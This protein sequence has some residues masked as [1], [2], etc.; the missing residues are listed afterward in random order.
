MH[1]LWP[2]AIFSS[3]GLLIALVKCRPFTTMS[4]VEVNQWD[5]LSQFLF[6]ERKFTDLIATNGELLE[7]F[8]FEIGWRKCNTKNEQF[9]LYGSLRKIENAKD[10]W[11]NQG[12]NV[13]FVGC[14]LGQSL[15]YVGDKLFQKIQTFYKSLGVSSFDQVNYE[16]DISANL[17]ALEFAPA[18]TFTMNGF[19]NSPHLDKDALLYA[20]G[21]WFQADKRTGPI[22]RDASKWCTGGKLIF[23]NEHFWIDLSKSYGLLVHLF[24][25]LIQ[26]MEMKAQ[27]YLVCPH[28]T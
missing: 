11:R 20:S 12:P 1:S 9:G 16:A 22:Q 5:E 23:P 17:G 13:S 4:E 7:V 26:H 8:M 24:I 18:I 28:N 6:R 25:I 19:K 3:T 15:G 10:E 21:W 27:H 14:I 2:S